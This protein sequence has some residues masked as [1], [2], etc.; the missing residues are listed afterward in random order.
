M[1]FAAGFGTRLC[2][3]TKDTPKPMIKVADRPL[4]DHALAI[5]DD[6][7]IEHC[8]INLHY[9]SDI[10]SEHLRE[11]KNVTLVHEQPDLLDT[12]G[13]LLNAL[14]VL[15]NQPLFTLNSDVVWKGPN[16]IQR[17][18]EAWNPDRADALLLVAPHEN[19]VGR[20]GGSDF[21]IERGGV[22][23]RAEAGESGVVYT[24]A[25][26]INPNC[27]SEVG[28]QVFSLNVVWN[29][30]MK[31]K[32]LVGVIYDGMIGDAGHPEGLAASEAMLRQP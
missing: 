7:G 19:V 6:A 15:G 23:R 5:M 27:L 16:P 3:L 1:I 8:A 32:R 2:A 14:D 29:Q 24:G 30:M 31:N 10:L 21:V 22:L 17:I 13:G 11:R 18:A 9:L 20:Q 12:G 28:K 4:I 25:Q 26:L